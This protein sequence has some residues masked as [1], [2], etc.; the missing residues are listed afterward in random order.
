MPKELIFPQ[1]IEEEDWEKDVSLEIGTSSPSGLELEYAKGA[2]REDLFVS[3][4]GTDIFP[5]DVIVIND[6]YLDNI[7]TSAIKIQSS[8]DVFVAETLRTKSPIVTS[9]GKQ[10]FILDL[11]LVFKPGKAQQQ[12]LHRLIAELSKTPFTFIFN[13]KIKKALAVKDF[14]TTL[15]VLE[16]GNLRSVSDAVGVVALDLT[17]HL[18]NYKPFSNHCY[19]NARLGGL[20]KEKETKAEE[21]GT[22]IELGGLQG[23][24][25]D[26]YTITKHTEKVRANIQ[27]G[28]EATKSASQGNIP[29][30]FPSESDAWMYYANRLE[31]QVQQITD[32]PSDYIG[33]A[34]QEY[35]YISPPDEAKIGKSLKDFSFDNP[36]HPIRAPYVANN[37]DST[38]TINQ[39]SVDELTSLES[40]SSIKTKF[41]NTKTGQSISVKLLTDQN[42]PSAEAAYQLS[43]LWRVGKYSDCAYVQLGLVGKLALLSNR[44]PGRT[45]RIISAS[46]KQKNLSKPPSK[47][48]IGQAM[49]LTID[50]VP[51]EEIFA[52]AKQQHKTGIGFYPNST[53]V[54]IDHR[55]K[56]TYWIDLSGP[57]E[58]ANYVSSN[59]RANWLRDYYQTHNDIEEDT[60][61]INHKPDYLSELNNSKGGEVS[62]TQEKIDRKKEQTSPNESRKKSLEA[63]E[64]WIKA[65]ETEGW[66]YY[67]KDKKIKNLFFRK[68]AA[69][70]SGDF[71]AQQQGLVLPNIVCSA[72][73]LSFGHRISPLRLVGQ[74]YYSY[75]FLGAGNRTGQIVF[76][77][78]GKTGQKSADIIKE[79]IYKAQENSRKFGALVKEAGAVNVASLSYLT[80]DQ[81][82]LLALLGVENIVVTGIEDASSPDSADKNQLLIEFIVQDFAEETIEKRLTTTLSSKQRIIKSIMGMLSSRKA[83]GLTNDI[84][85]IYPNRSIAKVNLG[86]GRA[87]EVVEGTPSWVAN[88]AAKAAELCQDINN[89]MPPVK[90]RAN[91]LAAKTWKDNYSEWGAGNLFNGRVKNIDSEEKN[92][93]GPTFGTLPGKEIYESVNGSSNAPSPESMY[94][95]VF[96]YDGGSK[97]NE[98]HERVFLEWLSRMD[99]L[100][101]EVN[102]YAADEENFEKYFGN[103]GLELL[104]EVSDSLGDCCS[105]LDLPNVPGARVPLPPEF[106]FYDDSDEDPLISSLTDRKN[107]E[108]L[109]QRHIFNEL[110]SVRRFMKDCFLGGAYLSKNLPRILENRAVTVNNFTPEFNWMGHFANMFGEGAFA[111]DPIFYREDPSIDSNAG[112]LSWK[113]LIQSTL[114]GGSPEE[115]R[116]NFIDNLVSLSGYLKTDRHWETP[117]TDNDKQSIV[118]SLY[119]EAW[120]RITFGPNPRYASV[121]TIWDGKPIDSNTL[122]GRE[123]ALEDKAK[124]EAKAKDKQIELPGHKTVT[125]K[126]AVTVGSLEAEEQSFGDQFLSNVENAFTVENLVDKALGSLG[127]LGTVISTVGDTLSQFEKAGYRSVA[128]AQYLAALKHPIADSVTEENT[129]ETLAKMTSG[130]AL[131]TKRNDLSFRRAFPTLKVL[132][133]EDDSVDTKISGGKVVRAFDDFYSYSAIQE[134]RV[135]RSRKMASDLAVLRMTNIGGKLLRHRFGEEEYKKPTAA[136][137]ERQGIFADTERENP[138]ERMIL[139]D[140]VKVQIRLGY[141]GSA[142]QLETVF[143]G[144]IVETQLAEDGKILEIMIQGYGAELES[145]ELG[146]LEDGPVFYSS[147]QVLSGAII[148]DSIANFGRQDRS[149]RF[150]PAEIRNAWTGGQGVGS[151]GSFTGLISSWADNKM[152]KLLAKYTFLNY[153]QDDNIFAP[154]PQLY[155]SEWDRF[156][157]NACIYRPLKQTP[158]QIFK[159]H[160]L[161]HPGYVSLAVPYG[162]EPRMTM[163]FGAKG[164]H[165]WARPPSALEVYLSENATNEIIKLRK[166][167]PENDLTLNVQ[168]RLR[169]LSSQSPNITNAIIE[170]LLSNGSPNAV[171]LELGKMFGRYVPFRNYHYFD[172]EHHILKNNIRTSVDGTYNEVELLFFEDEDKLQDADAEDLSQS[173]AEMRREE[174]GM[175]SVKLDENIPESALRSYRDEF[176]SC[177]TVEMARRYAQGIFARYLRDTYKG[178]LIVIGNEKIKP[179]DVCYLKDS[180]CDMSGPI[181]VEAVTHIFNRDSGFVSVIT[182]D[183]CVEVNDMFS[184]STLDLAASAMTYVWALPRLAIN[185]SVGY[186]SG[187]ST[188][189]EF[190]S[191]TAGIKL[192]SWTQDGDPV[193][194]TPLTLGGKP[195]CSTTFGP[196]NTTL[197]LNLFGQW[198]QYKEDLASAWDDFDFGEAFLD[199]RLSISSKLLTLLGTGAQGGVI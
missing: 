142:K 115:Q 40:D 46:R 44:F 65:Q 59:D 137:S 127:I 161:R 168:Q 28:L 184:V 147:Q 1:S 50:G 48:A 136:S 92:G 32:S 98:I 162:H 4:V 80:G 22:P 54:H 178:E 73:S 186:L 179:Y 119:G 83:A 117:Y 100:V 41:I 175:L 164:Q 165:Y 155:T 157:N 72:L 191:A 124:R 126:G 8:P 27:K 188:G 192:A 52:F 29:V 75:Q 197:F 181:E 199:T 25:A 182:P 110:Q 91:K 183:L 85:S 30:A 60:D 112:V 74:P 138:F 3:F 88:I 121:D 129:P 150:N 153:P 16:F 71:S 12:K 176:P 78:A 97:T 79:I 37:P 154:P 166:M 148:Q 195:F 101:K 133:I 149:N 43:K 89:K 172:S 49:D 20:E 109:L 167:G 38:R 62:K 45:I 130:I 82:I 194:I 99:V 104:D 86:T 177:V 77:Y 118:E 24:E 106:Y 102:Q 33:L 185:E 125:N 10:D 64:L 11:S 120:D 141:S 67:S 94:S 151:I 171:N 36:L 189:V 122:A 14:E 26:E 13:N 169:S 68:I 163:F 93:A 69:N 193:V 21:V 18:C 116:L 66:F 23:F 47:H 39:Q 152:D 146:P 105:D 63:R 87:Y 17:F 190:L 134:I 2:E 19:Y 107:L 35:K 132:F 111:W 61:E 57:G 131:G 144:Q 143:L 158:W 145:I 31:S 53:F 173:I 123:A 5:D 95:G 51:N 198:K 42:E 55:E 70:V 6:V 114:G 58:K 56:S 174:D 170:D 7:P 84:T 9:K 34:V 128:N 140:G 81:N 180:T 90:W 113:N 96:Q 76:T 187:A 108:S 139:Q 196:K 103:I 156:W 135:T 160:E 159:E 15:F